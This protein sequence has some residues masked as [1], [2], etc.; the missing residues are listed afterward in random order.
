MFGLM[1]QIEKG[2]E[3]VLQGV[4]HQLGPLSGRQL[5]G[6]C[7]FAETPLCGDFPAGSSTYFRSVLRIGNGCMGRWREASGFCQPAEQR[8]GIEQQHRI[9]ADHSL[10]RTPESPCSLRAGYVQAVPTPVRG[11]G[12]YHQVRTH[13]AARRVSTTADIPNLYVLLAFV[14]ELPRAIAAGNRI[15]QNFLQASEQVVTL[16][17]RQQ[18]RI[19]RLVI[20]KLFGTVSGKSI[21]VL[22]FASK[23]HTIDTRKSPAI[24][25]CRDLLKD[26][27]ST[28]VMGE[29]PSTGGRLGRSMHGQ[30]PIS[31]RPIPPISTC[32]L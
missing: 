11:A 10:V 6:R 19:A 20:T 26:L 27:A 14:R 22:G 16:N 23:A 17:T 2:T 5:A 25:I 29:V 31:E 7:E 30:W 24:R 1:A 9:G 13:Q 12:A 4:R 21:G 8:M 3:K 32:G 18:R 28:Q 15:C